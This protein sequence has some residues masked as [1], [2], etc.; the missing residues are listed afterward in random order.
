MNENINL[1]LHL[2]HITLLV[3]DQVHRRSMCGYPHSIL[4]AKLALLSAGYGGCASLALDLA[5]SLNAYTFIDISAA[6]VFFFLSFL[7]SFLRSLHSSLYLPPS[8]TTAIYLFLPL[9]SNILVSPQQSKC[10][11]CPTRM[12]STK[13]PPLP[14][15]S[16]P[17]QPGQTSQTLE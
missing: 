1:T 7:H 17:V 14:F 12:L 6:F 9:R 5:L 15:P 10:T 13:Y 16:R 3:N 4:S 8:T 2:P 11:A